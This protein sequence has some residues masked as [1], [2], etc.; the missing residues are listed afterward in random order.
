[1]ANTA[2]R[3]RASACMGVNGGRQAAMN[4]SHGPPPRLPGNQ[5]GTRME[6][7]SFYFDAKTVLISLGMVFV[8]IPIVIFMYFKDLF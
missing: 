4:L 7:F 2:G 8:L 1:M 6:V 3:H 5:K